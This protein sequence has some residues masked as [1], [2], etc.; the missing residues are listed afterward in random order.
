MVGFATFLNIPW[1]AKIL[2]EIQP[3]TQLT[4]DIER[5]RHVD[6]A[7]LVL[8]QDWARMAPVTGSS[9][10]VDWDTLKS[11][12]EGGDERQIGRAHV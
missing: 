5:L 11:R 12:S 6:Y 7:V 3:G 9:L 1:I 2:D 10:I 4:L 8:L